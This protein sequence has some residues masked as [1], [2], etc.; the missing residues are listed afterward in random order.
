MQLMQMQQAQA[1]I[2][3]RAE[4]Q[5]QQQPVEEQSQEGK[6]DLSRTPEVPLAATVK[7]DEQGDVVSV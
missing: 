4:Q 1:Q 3:V 5:P 7:P 6:R 2:Q